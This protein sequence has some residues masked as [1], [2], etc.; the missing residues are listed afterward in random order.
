MTAPVRGSGCLARPFFFEH[1]APMAVG[2]KSLRGETVLAARGWE[3][4][5]RPVP[6]LLLRELCE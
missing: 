6:P 2:V 1:D 5:G 4:L 3:C